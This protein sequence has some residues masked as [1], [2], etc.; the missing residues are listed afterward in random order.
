MRCTSGLDVVR[1]VAVFAHPSE[2]VVEA[3]ARFPGRRGQ[4]LRRCLAHGLA[5]LVV[6]PG[7]TPPPMHRQLHAPTVNACRLRVRGVRGIPGCDPWRP[8]QPSASRLGIPGYA[9]CAPTLFDGIPRCTRIIPGLPRLSSCGPCTS[10][11]TMAL[12]IS[13]R[14]PPA[15]EVTCWRRFCRG[16]DLESPLER[17][18]ETAQ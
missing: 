7:R 8:V 9:R 4:L 5:K 1:F 6:L 13:R 11:D 16:G 17:Q 3:A 15:L 18:P 2:R 12:P 14:K 10:S